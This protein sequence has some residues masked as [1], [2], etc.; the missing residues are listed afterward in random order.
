VDCYVWVGYSCVEQQTPY[1]SL[2][3]GLVAPWLFKTVGTLEGLVVYGQHRF[4]GP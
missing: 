1:E 3:L 4:V 2:V